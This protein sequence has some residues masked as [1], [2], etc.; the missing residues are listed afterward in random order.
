VS[1]GAVPQ[2][3]VSGAAPDPTR[4]PAHY[5]FQNLTV[6]R[7]LVYGFS[8]SPDPSDPWFDTGMLAFKASKSWNFSFEVDDLANTSTPTQLNLT[9]WGEDLELP[10]PN[11]H[12]VAKLNG[13]QILDAKFNGWVKKSFNISVPAGVLQEGNNTLTLTLPGD[14][15]A[16]YD[17]IYLDKYTVTYPHSFSAR[18]GQLTF[19]AAG[20]IF[21]VTDLP[22]PDIEVYATDAQG[23]Q[24][25]LENLL[26]QPTRSGY[27][28]VF[29][30]SDSYRTYFVTTVAALQAPSLA[31]ASQP[32][33]NFDQP[34]DYLIIAH[35]DFIDGLSRL[36]Q[37]RQAQGLTVNV[38]NVNDLY[39]EYSNGVFD[40][41]AIK[42]YITYAA[43][44]LGTQYVLLVGGDSYDYRDYLGLNSLSFI[45]S[46]YG[47][48]NQIKF[49]PSD[50]L[51][52]D[53]NNDGVPEIAI[54]RFPV[55]T[56]A[57]LNAMIDKTLAFAGKSYNETAFFA[58]DK[59][60]GKVDFT[61]MSDALSSSL[62]SGWTVQSTYL[63]TTG[64]STA[65]SQLIAAM[66]NGTALVNY[67]GHSS[68][69]QWSALNLFNTTN[70]AALNNAG[71]P[72]VVVQYGCWNTYAVSPTGNNLVQA[73]LLTGDQGAAA[74]LGSVTLS[75]ASSEQS[76]GELLTPLLA[77]PGLTVG[78]ALMTAKQQLNATRPNLV[79]VQ[80]G[81]TLMGDPALIV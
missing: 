10:A 41:Q 36:V 52:A 32:G 1:S 55:R 5:Y 21:E 61:K 27:S 8:D 16:R 35:P 15:G 50:E 78:Q 79:D 49:V 43:Q 71:K 67:S 80:M 34:A 65:K 4:K 53:T 66:N 63:D 39:T 64:V 37:A 12:L 73:F 14:T 81:W 76:L 62:P 75:L 74:V 17:L 69:D 59:N 54:G 13:T 70:A 51:Y 72:F 28:V 23:T 44:N 77:Q 2:I 48:T 47:T 24:S 18:D 58:A 19:T 40:P 26:I 45:P 46:L 25:R 7:Q 29:A 33:G 3:P 31:A 22:S 60:D 42:Q 57:E 11:H 20:S 56:S 6:N 38:V 30:G 9:V 68:T